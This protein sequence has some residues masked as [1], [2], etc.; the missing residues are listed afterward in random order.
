M[1][2]A[3]YV[4]FGAAA[5]PKVYY[6]YWQWCHEPW[7]SLTAAQAH[8]TLD[9]IRRICDFCRSKNIKLMLTSV[10]HYWQYNGNEQGTGA[11]SFSSRPHKEIALVAQRCGV[12]YHNAFEEL[13]PLIVGT[14]QKKYYNSGDI[15]FNPRGYEIWADAQYRFLTDSANHLLP[16]GFY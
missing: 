2:A 9:Y 15:H 14:P 16:Q 8:A 1:P 7:D 5:P 6:Q 13:K 10:P 11:P 4:N 12:P 3:A